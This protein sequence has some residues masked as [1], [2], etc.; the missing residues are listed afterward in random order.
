MRAS[1]YLI[2][3]KNGFVS[4]RKSEY[5]LKHGQVAVKLNFDLPVVLFKQPILEG[6][7]KLSEE[8]I[9]NKVIKELEFELK[10]LKEWGNKQN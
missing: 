10:N 4:S 3:D 7:I 2:F 5:T 8:E 9:G 1:V 6:E